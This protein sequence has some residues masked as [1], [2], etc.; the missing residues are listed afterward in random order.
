M[1]NHIPSIILNCHTLILDIGD[2]LFTWSSQTSTSISPG[3]FHSITTSSTWELYECGKLTQD[4]CYCLCA[5]EWSLDTEEL[6]RALRLAGQSISIDHDLI[7]LIR[8]LKVEMGSSL[9]VFAM[10]N[11]SHPDYTFL[12]EH[13]GD[14]DWSIFD[15]VFTS[16]AAGMRKP[17]LCFYRHVLEITHSSPD[18]TV[19]V[20]DKVENVLVARSFG[21]QG[22][23]FSSSQ[24]A[25][26]NIRGL[27]GSPLARGKAYLDS[28][29]NILYST[30]T[31]GVSFE[32]N[33]TQLLILEV[34]GQRELV[35]LASQ[36]VSGRWNF[37]K[38]KPVLT[39]TEYPNDI[40][41]TS[42]AM[43]VLQHDKEL[44]QRVMDEMLAFKSPDGIIEMY[45]DH[46]RR[47]TDAVVCLNA[48]TLFYAQ[49]RGSDLSITE[50]WVFDVLKNRAYIDGTRYYALAECFLYLLSRL[51]KKAGDDKL[52]ER[53]LPLLKEHLQERVGAPG[54]AVALA[55]RIVACAYVGIRD[56]TDTR[57][58]LTMQL[59]DGSWEAG[60]LY[61]YGKSGIGI[62]N[63]GFTTALALEA[64]YSVEGRG[65]AA[66]M[67]EYLDVPRDMQ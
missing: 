52:R 20:D 19:F 16:A 26:A 29:A 13:V 11:M 46:N 54:N 63:A 33:F 1:S 51:L 45:F 57:R 39:T 49:G 25:R 38:G 5:D 41:T 43:T 22:V 18:T 40:D 67:W 35:D 9:R 53:F 64:V 60:T 24:G 37:F 27:F 21:M 28:H 8:Q 44:I 4:E 10:T 55:M 42:I 50:S 61:K 32:D 34:T 47:R 30:T 12:R 3:T 2:V 66:E 56:E 15:E 23:V 65:H 17:D 59:E 7:S 31:T 58:L 36:S 6:G 62:G 48:L 14:E